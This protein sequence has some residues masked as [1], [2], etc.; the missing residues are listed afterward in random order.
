[1]MSTTNDT[2]PA[3]GDSSICTEGGGVEAYR[4]VTLSPS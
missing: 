3:I 4:A 1:M 2:R